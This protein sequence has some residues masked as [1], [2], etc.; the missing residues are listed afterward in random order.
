[1]DRHLPLRLLRHG[2]VPGF[3]AVIATAS[4]CGKSDTPASADVAAQPTPAPVA[5]VAPAPAP[6][7]APEPAPD[8][9]AAAT[10]DTAAAPAQGRCE[11]AEVMAVVN[12]LNPDFAAS[13][14][15][16]VEVCGNID[17]ERRA[18]L[19]HTPVADPAALKDGALYTLS[20]RALGEDDTDH[21]PDWP[22]G[23]DDGLRR[24]DAQ[25]IIK[26]C[27]DPSRGCKD[28]FV[29]AATAAHFDASRSR[30]ILT[31]V[32]DD[33]AKTVRVFKVADLTQTLEVPLPGT[34][35]VDCS[36]GAF[37]GDHIVV[38]SG[39]CNSKEGARAWLVHGE[40]GER[41][42]DI[43]GKADFAL[44]DGHFTKVADERWAFRAADGAQLVVMDVRSGETVATIDT[45]LDP[46]RP[47]REKAW[48]LDHGANKVVLVEAGAKGPELVM[49]DTTTNAVLG[50]FAAGP[51]CP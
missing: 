31:T 4:A 36:F 21:L 51:A 1:M 29:G 35:L 6:D 26:M 41:I 3:M 33:G 39:P 37:V 34:S 19:V 42:A 25:P 12:T 48:V 10:P 50:R 43:G 15:G 7:A 18:C 16:I 45:G 23:F 32:N 30:A 44:R 8:V 5:D 24:D 46:A 9:A 17:D 2:F 27:I 28:L 11:S 47:N 38:A 49:V 14:E 22:I 20:A 13:T 40:T